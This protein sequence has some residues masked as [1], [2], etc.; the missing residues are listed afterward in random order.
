MRKQDQIKLSIDTE[1]PRGTFVHIDFWGKEF[2]ALDV[3]STKDLYNQ[4][5]TVLSICKQWEIKEDCE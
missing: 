2:I 1:N 4:L 5:A 3:K